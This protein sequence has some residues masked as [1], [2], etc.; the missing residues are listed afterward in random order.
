MTVICFGDSNTFGYDYIDN[1]QYLWWAPSSIDGAAL[2]GLS[3]VYIFQTSDLTNSTL[4]RY[5]DQFGQHSVNALAGFEV[6]D[7][8]VG[9]TYSGANNYP[10][11]KL[12]ALSVGQMY[13]VGGS[14]SRSFMM[15][16]LGNVNYDYDNR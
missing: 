1:K 14:N 11:D 6:A 10:G 8:R 5:G 4:L 15:S 2:N 16:L 12:N 9:Y 3:A 7:H 13:G